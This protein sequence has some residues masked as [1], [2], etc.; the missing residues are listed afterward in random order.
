LSCVNEPL[1]FRVC[2]YVCTYVCALSV[3]CLFL[4]IQ[5]LHK[6]E[7]CS[8]IFRSPAHVT[9]G[10]LHL[11]VLT[12]YISYVSN[13]HWTIGSTVTC[14]I[15]QSCLISHASLI[16]FSISQLHTISVFSVYGAA[17]SNCV[18]VIS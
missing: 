2:L 8:Y 17:K 1:S 6:R 7:L 15:C 11:Q 3:T 5:H 4:L 12:R 10:N 18:G 16:N 9:L 14:S 13:A